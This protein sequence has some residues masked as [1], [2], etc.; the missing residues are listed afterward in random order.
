MPF[1]RVVIGNPHFTESIK[2]IPAGN[3]ARKYI[4]ILGDGIETELY[5][6]LAKHVAEIARRRCMPVFF[7]PHPIERDRAKQ[8][9]FPLGVELD[10]NSDVYQ[11][12]ALASTVISELSTGL[13][14]AA[15]LVDRV[16][17]W[18]TA[19]ARFAFPELPFP[20]F[21]SFSELDDSRFIRNQAEA[22]IIGSHIAKSK[23]YAE[24]WQL[25][26]KNFVESVISK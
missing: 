11:S 7:R 6:D 26:Y 21:T 17:I 10:E 4:L 20:S 22:C 2:H 16:V 12:F 25:N 23:T 19:K 18:N 15:G 3:S 14:E 1:K 5:L 8:M 9:G 24:N 13:F